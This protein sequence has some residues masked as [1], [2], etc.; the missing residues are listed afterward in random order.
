M[1][2]R[3]QHAEPKR[4]PKHDIHLPIPAKRPIICGNKEF[5]LFLCVMKEYRRQFVLNML[6]YAVQRDVSPGEL[7]RLS[8]LDL[9]GLKKGEVYSITTKQTNDLWLNALHLTHDEAFGLHFGESVQLS[10]LGVVGQII[11]S[12]KTVGEAL[13]QAGTAM[14]LVTDVFSMKVNQNGK[15]NPHSFCDRKIGR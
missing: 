6:A 9:D 15:K 14:H 2:Q 5:T 1:N 4:L 13:I 7:C 8:H 3:Y 11:Q 12:S 10:A